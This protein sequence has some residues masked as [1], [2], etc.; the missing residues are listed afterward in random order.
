MSSIPVGQAS[1]EDRGRQ[2]WGWPLPVWL[3]AGAVVLAELAF[4][5]R[6]GLFRDEFYYLACADHLAWGYV[7]HPPLSIAVL[8]L[9]R[10]VLGDSILAVRLTPALLVGG[11]VLLGSRLAQALG[12]GRFAQTLAALAVAAAPQYLGQGGYYSM[13]SFDLVFWAGAALLVARLTPDDGPRRFLFLGLILGLG[14]LNKISVL[15]FGAGLAAALILTP[16][17]R[18][19]LRIGPWLALVAAGLLFLPHLG[20]QMLHDWPTREFVENATRYKNVA[21]SPLQFLG[22]Q[23]LEINPLNAPLWIAGLFWLLLA[24]R[25]RP[26]RSLG[27]IYLVALGVMILQHAKPYYLGPAYPPLLA[28]GAV[29]LE[30]LRWRWL[31]PVAV[32]ALAI[33]GAAL[34]PFAMPVLP[35]ETFIS[36]QKAIG[37]APPQGERS[38][39]G[40]LPQFFADRFGWQELTEAVA[41]AYRSLP[42]EDRGRVVIVTSNYGEAGALNYYGRRHGLPPAV[43]QHNSFYLWGPGTDTVEVAITV[44]MN[45][46]DLKDAWTSIEE[47]GRFHSPYAMPYQQRHPILICRGLKLPLPDAWRQGKRFI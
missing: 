14:L 4:G 9:V 39:L 21:M 22:A 2:F 45:P 36:Y 29:W 16:L 44:G 28:A 35:V 8:K 37:L 33:S 23:V 27:I 24:R 47:A 46:E 31:R 38:A 1:N 13:N 6:Y 42:A 41:R 34:A 15:F 30:S 25:A 10:A 12:G 32:T 26:Y 43:S 5:P 19:L 3:L 11:L 40:P 18:Q 20:W 17:R 7:D